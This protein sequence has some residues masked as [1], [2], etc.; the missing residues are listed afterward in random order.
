[1]HHG[2]ANGVMIDLALEHNVE[3]VPE[4]FETMAITVGLDDPSPAT[5][6]RWLG[7][8]KRDVGVP[9]SLSATDVPAD[10]IDVLTDLAFEDACWPNGPRPV[11]PGD[12]RL[13][14]EKAFA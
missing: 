9:A 2:L 11:T 6:L 7:E 8:L 3:A 5:F 10:R 4:R 13:I 1:M 14:F 12:F